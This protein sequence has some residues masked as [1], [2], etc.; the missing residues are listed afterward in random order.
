MDMGLMLRGTSVERMRTKT[1]TWLDECQFMVT[2]TMITALERIM[3]LVD[4]W[5]MV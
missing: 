1:L 5:Q 2:L 4:P 3:R